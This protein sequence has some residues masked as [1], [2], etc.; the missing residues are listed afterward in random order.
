MPTHHASS[1]ICRLS[2]DLIVSHYTLSS[3]QCHTLITFLPRHVCGLSS[4]RMYSSA[5]R[6]G[7]P[8]S[9]FGTWLASLAAYDPS[10]LNQSNSLDYSVLAVEPGC[11][12]CCRWA[13]T[14]AF[15]RSQALQCFEWIGIFQEGL[16]FLPFF[17]FFTHLFIFPSTTIGPHLDPSWFTGSLG[18]IPGW[19]RHG[20]SRPTITTPPN[21][22]F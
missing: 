1:L 4:H 6:Q 15:L 18:Q 2:F 12:Q 13:I 10:Q 8:T 16:V 19:P 5:G 21:I 9:R 22:S 7:L 20:G 11:N 14:I 3:M 17:S